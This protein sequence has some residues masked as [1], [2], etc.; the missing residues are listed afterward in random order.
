MQVEER[1]TGKVE[2]RYT[3][4]CSRGTQVRQRRG[5]QVK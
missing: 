3:D 1:F 2:K 5:T 4:W